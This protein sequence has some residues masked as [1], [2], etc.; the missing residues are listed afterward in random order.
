MMLNALDRFRPFAKFHT[1]RHFKYIIARRDEHKEELQSYY[2]LTEE[3]MEE[4]TKEW[5]EEILVPVNHTELSDPDLIGSLV[6]TR[7]EYDAPNSRGKKKKED[8]H[9]IHKTSEETTSDS[10][11]RGGD[12]EVDKEEKEG[13]EDKQN[14]GEVTLPRNPL[15]EAE[16]SK[17]IKVSPMKP[18]SRKKSKASN[19]NMQI[20]LMVDDFNFI[21]IAISDASEDILQRNEAK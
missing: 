15:E 9:E 18:T 16:T 7:E 17:K 12:N 3:D 2:K 11:S 19:P 4:I 21:I 13:E 20:V 14:Q 1:D 5:S 6:V 8:V 10:P